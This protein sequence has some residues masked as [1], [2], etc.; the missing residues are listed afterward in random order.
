MLWLID[1]IQEL[2]RRLVAVELRHRVTPP[3]L[4]QFRRQNII[5][6]LVPSFL[7]LQLTVAIVVL[8]GTCSGLLCP[9]EGFAVDSFELLSGSRLRASEGVLG[10]ESE[11]LSVAHLHGRPHF[12]LDRIASFFERSAQ[13]ARLLV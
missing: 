5:A 1:L 11:I 9:L 7:M 3:L 6:P 2:P 10:R 8:L 12:Q 13:N 4:N